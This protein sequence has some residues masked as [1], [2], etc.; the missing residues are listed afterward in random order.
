[1]PEADLGADRVERDV[2]RLFGDAEVGDAHRQR[3]ASCSRRTARAALP[4]ATI[5]S[6]PA[7][8]MA[9]GGLQ[10][11]AGRIDD[12]LQRG[13]LREDPELGRGSIL[14]ANS[15]WSVASI[16][17]SS[18]MVSTGGPFSR[19]ASAVAARRPP[20]ELEACASACRGCTAAR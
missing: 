11:G 20:P 7:C 9:V 17:A 10:L 18:L 6:V 13:E 12:D 2:E 19:S 16:S 4:P 8:A 15:S 14:S 1:M 5:S 3:C